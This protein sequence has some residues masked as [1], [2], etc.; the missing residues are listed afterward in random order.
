MRPSSGFAPNIVKRLDCVLSASTRSGC[1]RP[2]KVNVR[3]C[4]IAIWS[5]E[6]F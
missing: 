4:A 3:L 2:V 5:N 1:S 6:W